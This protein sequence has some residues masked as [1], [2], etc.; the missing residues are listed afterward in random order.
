MARATG[1]I[2]RI[3]QRF[4][5]NRPLDELPLTITHRRVYVLPT[6]RGLAFGGTLIVMLIA[7]INYNL[8]LG[9]G[10]AFL[11][12]GLVA[13]ALITTYRTL[14]GIE[15]TAVS[16]GEAP[17][18]QPVDFHIR[19]TN[20]SQS[21]RN[22][23]GVS[24]ISPLT[25][26]RLTAPVEL[27]AGASESVSIDVP[28]LARGWQPMGRLTLSTRYP[29]GLWVA[30]C[31]VHTRQ[32]ALVLPVPERNP[33]PLPV[34]DGGDADARRRVA[35]AG[36]FGG[37]RNYLP[38]DSP[39]QIAWKAAARG[40]GLQTRIHET[41]YASD[42]RISLSWRDCQALADVEARL[43][44]LAGWVVLADS[45]GIPFSLSLPEHQLAEGQGDAHRRAA[46]RALAQ[47]GQPDPTVRTRVQDG[48]S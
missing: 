9:Y 8:N 6:P 30:W 41:S 14:A 36:E 47:H 33:P 48:G 31:Y 27:D 21:R 12:T 43:C 18:G 24:V 20:H 1:A 16:T 34:K 4:F 42:Q 19:V 26:E 10:L 7:S 2:A 29:V 5:R 46:M 32:A 37:L 15:V 28:T 3:R 13:A 23:I 38:G 17:V 25:S 45:Q 35:L 22:G 11:L 40:L 39:S 44:R